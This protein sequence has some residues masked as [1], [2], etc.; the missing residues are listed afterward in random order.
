MLQLTSR[1]LPPTTMTLLSIPS[2][3]VVL[4]NIKS[5]L[6]VN[7]FALSSSLLSSNILKYDPT[8]IQWDNYT[9]KAFLKEVPDLSKENL[10]IRNS[11]TMHHGYL[12]LLNKKIK[13]LFVIGSISDLSRYTFP[14]IKIPTLMDESIIKKYPGA[15]PDGKFPDTALDNMH[16][17]PNTHMFI[18]KYLLD[19]INVIH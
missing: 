17:G 9:D 10:A 19:K 15:V 11:I 5:L 14:N 18:A 7:T 4:H 2:S 1:L 16:P 8:I 3:V 13:H 6:L 12:H